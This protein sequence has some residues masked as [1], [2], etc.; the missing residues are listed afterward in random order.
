MCCVVLPWQVNRQSK[1]HHHRSHRNFVDKL[2]EELSQSFTIYELHIE[3]RFES[4]L[5][6]T[7]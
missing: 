6:L 5:L 3:M 2:F 4:R 7:S 1:L